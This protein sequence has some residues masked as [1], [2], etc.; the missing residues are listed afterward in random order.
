MKLLKTAGEGLTILIWACLNPATS[1]LAAPIEVQ[2][3][4]S[5][6]IVLALAQAREKDTVFLPAGT[7]TLLEPI[8][9]GSG[10]RLLGAGQ[11]ASE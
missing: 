6:A 8:H 5:E 10:V 11:D 3:R 7:Y 4:H 1:G 2:G 9:P